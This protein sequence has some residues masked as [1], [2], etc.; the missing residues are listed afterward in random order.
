MT[1]MCRRLQDMF[2]RTHATAML[3]HAFLFG[4]GFFESTGRAHCQPIVLVLKSM[5]KE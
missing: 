2:L 5:K 1:Q 3:I 4:F